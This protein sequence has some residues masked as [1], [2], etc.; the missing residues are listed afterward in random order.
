MWVEGIENVQ[1]T[2]SPAPV[3]EATGLWSAYDFNMQVLNMRGD[4]SQTASPARISGK[5]M[6]HAGFTSGFGPIDNATSIHLQSGVDGRRLWT[7]DLPAFIRENPGMD[8]SDIEVLISFT[9]LGVEIKVPAWEDEH[10]TPR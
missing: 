1:N 7:V 5:D 3:V 6:Y 8:R 4:F 10:V 2:L 9:S